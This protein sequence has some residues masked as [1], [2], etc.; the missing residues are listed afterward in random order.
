MGLRLCLNLFAREH[1]LYSTW[2]ED[3]LGRKGVGEFEHKASKRWRECVVYMDPRT[4]LRR[5][6]FLTGQVDGDSGFHL[7]FFGTFS[8]AL[9][10]SSS[11]LSL[12]ATA[13]SPSYY[14][15][16]LFQNFLGRSLERFYLLAATL[17]QM[18]P[19]NWEEERGREGREACKRV[20]DCVLA[21]AWACWISKRGAW[22][23]ER[24][25]FACLPA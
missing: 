15:V 23:S 1:L 3:S 11:L 22:E 2:R 8:E 13:A 12:A 10:L 7:S 24:S 9:V 16:K 19:R 17:R 25:R 20:G 21:Y 18:G 5:W 4:V 6:G 14:F